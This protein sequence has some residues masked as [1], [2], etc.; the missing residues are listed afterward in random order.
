MKGPRDSQDLAT[1]AITRP[2]TPVRDYPH[3]I[4]KEVIVKG[5]K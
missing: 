2:A 5:T 1:I 3:T 4:D